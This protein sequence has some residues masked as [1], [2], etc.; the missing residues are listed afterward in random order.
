MA[1][2]SL[3]LTRELRVAARVDTVYRCLTD[4]EMIVKWFGRR[5]DAD[6]CVGGRIRIEV[7][8]TA[9]ASGEFVELV[10]NEKVAFTFGWEEKDHNLKPGASMVTF[11]LR[12]DGDHTVVRFTHSGLPTEDLVRSH[13][14]GW[15][16]Y[17]PRLK[18]LGEGKDPSASPD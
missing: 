13:S 1:T 11:E 12:P 10:P 3:E 2:R 18:A 7:N 15:D 8:P 17:L 4:P 9:T 6:P 16:R 14:E 5:V